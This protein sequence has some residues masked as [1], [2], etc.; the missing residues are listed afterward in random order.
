MWH[1]SGSPTSILLSLMYNRTEIHTA[2]LAVLTRASGRAY[3]FDDCGSAND[4]SFALQNF[5]ARNKCFIVLTIFSWTSLCI[6][7]HQEHSHVFLTSAAENKPAIC[8]Y[9]KQC[10]FYTSISVESYSWCSLEGIFQ[11]ITF[12]TRLDKFYS[13]K[14]ACNT[15]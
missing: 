6:L 1:R 5:L 11:Y 7:H 10:C 8:K 3:H 4:C 9:R 2:P 13:E 12:D 15:I 14:I